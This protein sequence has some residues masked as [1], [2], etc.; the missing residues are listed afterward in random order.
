MKK[1]LTALIALAVLLSFVGVVSATNPTTQASEL[2]Y[3]IDE[4]YNVTFP[5]ETKAITTSGTSLGSVV[6]LA[7][8]FL[9]EE[10]HHLQVTVTSLNYNNGWYLKNDGKSATLAYSLTADGESVVDGG[11][12]AETTDSTLEEDVSA[13]LIAKVTGTPTAS[14]AYKDTLTFTVT[15]V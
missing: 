9:L 3:E 7:E 2:T 4:T 12:V 11:V 1:L 5:A 8:N 15:S 13:E 10:G 14:G 6:I